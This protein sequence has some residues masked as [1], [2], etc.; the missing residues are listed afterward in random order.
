MSWKILSYIIEVR[1]QIL[2]VSTNFLLR[3]FLRSL[4]KHF[5]T[6]GFSQ[7]LNW[8]VV[9]SEM[10]TMKE[11]NRNHAGANWEYEVKF[12][13]PSKTYRQTD[14]KVWRKILFMTLPNSRNVLGT[15]LADSNVFPPVDLKKSPWKW[16]IGAC[17]GDTITFYT[18]HSL[19]FQHTYQ[20]SQYNHYFVILLST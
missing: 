12:S 14:L 16:S 18:L 17:S 13:R 6:I 4:R 8:M 5:P 7:H 15:K 2:H 19:H 1:D 3:E 10:L 20:L 11:E 9:H